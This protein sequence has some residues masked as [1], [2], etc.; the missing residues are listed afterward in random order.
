MASGSEAEKC[1][2]HQLRV[3]DSDVSFSAASAA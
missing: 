2:P 1:S 3:S